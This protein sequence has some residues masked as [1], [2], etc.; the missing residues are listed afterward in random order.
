M[1]IYADFFCKKLAKLNLD[2]I[3]GERAAFDKRLKYKENEC[4]NPIWAE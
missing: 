3:D 2:E 1:Q 4:P